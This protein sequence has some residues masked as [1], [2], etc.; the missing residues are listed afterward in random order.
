MSA[1]NGDTLRRLVGLSVRVRSINGGGRWWVTVQDAAPRGKTIAVKVGA[2]GRAIGFGK[3][4]WVDASDCEP[5]T[6]AGRTAFDAALHE[7]NY[8][9]MQDPGSA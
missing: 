6:V 7:A 4:R 5:T 1:A 8:A 9:N 2:C 3:P